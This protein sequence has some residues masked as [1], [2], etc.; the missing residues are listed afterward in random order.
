VTLKPVGGEPIL[1]PN[2]GQVD[3]GFGR[4]RTVL[5]AISGGAVIEL[6]HAENRAET[7]GLTCL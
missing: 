5:F 4:S 3:V 2:R 1:F 7:G 6:P